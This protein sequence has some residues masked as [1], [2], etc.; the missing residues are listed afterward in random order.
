MI[1]WGL[2]GGS[3]DRDIHF[4]LISKELNVHVVDLMMNEIADDF[5]QYFYGPDSVLHYFSSSQVFVLMFKESKM[6]TRMAATNPPE[7]P[8]L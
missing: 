7:N 6:G 5:F 2:L 3:G 4:F 8:L 1:S